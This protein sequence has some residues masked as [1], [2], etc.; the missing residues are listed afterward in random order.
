MP[1]GGTSFMAHQAGNES[2]EHFAAGLEDLRAREP[3]WRV[4]S[5]VFLARYSAS[6]C[7]ESISRYQDVASFVLADPE[8][9]RLGMPFADRGRGRGDFRYLSE[10]NP[11]ANRSRFVQAVLEAQAEVGSNILVSPWLTHGVSG[12]RREFNASIDFAER[13]AGNELLVG[14]ELLFG[15]EVTDAIVANRDER[16]YVLNQL[17]ELPSHPIYLRV[18]LSM[19]PPG[20][21]QY[22]DRASLQG[23]KAMV[24]SL[25]SNGLPVL[26]PQASLFGWLMLAFGALSFGGG[27]TAS[28]DRH[29]VQRSGGGGFPPLHWY[30]L[31]QFLGFVQVEELPSLE[32]ISGFEACD[33]PYCEESPPRPGE[34]FDGIAAG[35]HYLWWCARLANEVNGM[36]NR[37]AAV[38]SRLEAA[39]AFWNDVQEARVVL[40]GRSQPTHLGVW[41]QVAS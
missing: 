24:Q 2:R 40:D 7:L 17:V 19:T 25:S 10:S 22:A 4:G 35:R 8:T 23:L 33:C 5:T 32:S 16:D 27:V 9:H 21:K 13:A 28:S 14:R 20:R 37:P 29:T 26:L 11:M 6:Y 34:N 39:S 38:R 41:T 31:P 36:A 1:T 30:F 15:F 12:T 3:G 18:R